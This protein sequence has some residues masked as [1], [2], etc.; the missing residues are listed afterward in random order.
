[1]SLPLPPWVSST[2]DRASRTNTPIPLAGIGCFSQ[3]LQISDTGLVIKQSFEHPVLGNLQAAEKRIYE[4]LGTHP[5]ILRYYGEYSPK[6]NG[7]PRGLVFPYLWPLQA[8]EAIRYI[9]SKGVVHSD[10]GCHNFLVQD[11]GSLALADFG[12]SGIDDTR[13]VVSYSTR[14]ARPCVEDDE[15]REVDDLYALGTVIYEISVGYQLY[16]ESSSREVRKL[17][18]R[19]QYPDLQG[20]APEIRKALVFDVALYRTV[21]G[22]HGEKYVTDKALDKSTIASPVES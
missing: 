17:L 12:G 5:F 21:V 14:Y 7:L 1:M 6:E 15:S 8:A 11:D 2:L 10:I 22:D 3:V 20:L 16:P 18:H 4:R 9:H 13:A 19:G